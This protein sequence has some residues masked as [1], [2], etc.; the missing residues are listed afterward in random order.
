MRFASP[1]MSQTALR[2]PALPR[3]RPRQERSAVTV[4]AMIE[5]SVRILLAEG[6]ARLTTRRV[7]EVAGVSVG[8]LYQYFP[9]RRS[10]VAEVIRRKME[11]SVAA[12][13][14]A[15]QAAEGSP[16]DALAEVMGAFVAS[17]RRGIALS[18]ALLDAKPDVEW[19]DA[20]AEGARRAGTILAALLERL[21]ARPLDAA[22]VA[23]LAIAV[24]A[25]E[26]AVA[27]TAERDPAAFADPAYADT[28]AGLLLGALALD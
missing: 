15:A 13:S 27:A 8:S 5:A 9:H 26:G 24:S 4:D 1:V 12:I 23:R 16:R 25:L 19:R 28:L 11:G 2:D 3:K 20:V 14:A 21:L 6:Y 10:L 18:L 7:A 17:K 22:E